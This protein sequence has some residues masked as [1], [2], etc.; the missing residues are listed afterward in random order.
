MKNKIKFFSPLFFFPLTY[1]IGIAIT[2]IFIVIFTIFL[3]FS[4]NKEKFNNKNILLFLLLFSLYVAL[5]AI[6][7]IPSELKYSSIFHF[8]FFLFALSIYLFFTFYEKSELNQFFFIIPFIFIVILL[9]FDSGFQFFVG[10]N[11]LGQKINEHGYRIS[12]FFGENL[13]LGSFLMRLLPIILWYLFYMK[14][15][16]NSKKIISILFFSFYFFVIYISG[17]RTSFILTL[18]IIISIIIFVPNLRYIFVSSFLVF[19]ILAIL[20]P[21]LNIGKEDITHRMFKKTYNQL[22]EKGKT[23][24]QHKNYDEKNKSKDQKFDFTKKLKTINIFSLEHEGHYLIAIDLFKKNFIFGVGPKGFRHYCR[25]VNY[26]PPKGICSTHPHNTLIQ[27]LSEL[28][29]IGLIFYLI[30]IIFILKTFFKNIK[31]DTT[32]NEINGLLVISIGLLIN[33]FPFSPS[34]NFFNNWISSFIY[35]NVGLFLFSYKK[36]LLK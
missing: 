15:E 24:E 27:I 2:E 35:F 14:I 3:F 8:R 22:F 9:L 18:F 25:S 4:Y 12:S 20:L 26:D 30:F 1:I 29:I 31:K 7:Q 21:S 6:S 28:G 33:L 36:S 11:I 17:E 19:I 13:I 23:V 32:N 5:N 10:E 34:G 16:I